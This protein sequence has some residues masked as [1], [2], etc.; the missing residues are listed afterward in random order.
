[1]DPVSHLLLARLVA[2][3]RTTRAMPRGVV[4][5]TVVG[6]MAP[7]ADAALMA[8]GWD[9]YLRWHELG[10]H[11]LAGTPIVAA[12][13]A[14]FVR[15]WAPQTS[16]VALTLAAWCGVLSH[17][18]FDL[19]SGATIRVLW[20]LTA[21]PFTA[22]VVAMAD[23]LAIAILLFGAVTLWVWPRRPRAA[24]VLVMALLAALAGVKLTTRAWAASAYTRVASTG[25]QPDRVTMEAVWG[26]WTSWLVFDHLPD[27]RV[28]AWTAD[29][30]TGATRLRFDEP[31]RLEAPF[32][33]QSHAAFATVRNFMPVHPYAL[34][35]YRDNG[36]GGVVF[37]SDARFCWNPAERGDAQDDV[38]HQDMRPARGGV[39]CA[40]WFGG[41]YDQQGRPHESLVW[42]GGHLQRRSPQ[43]WRLDP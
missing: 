3:L 34:A 30:W 18:A 41:S 39:R 28:R 26:S 9:V 2:A 31:A 5:A 29:G 23:P 43:R 13:T 38:P 11:A 6:G 16:W 14:A 35:T 22:P 7:D 27:G 8:A 1:M 20:P 40:L 15:T 21:R 10:T 25:P 42:L 32:A 33:R 37:W 4:A 24:G 17:V 36:S 19:Y 12:L